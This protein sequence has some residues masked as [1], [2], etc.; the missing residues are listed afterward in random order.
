MQENRSF[1]NIFAGFPGAQ[2]ALSG[3]CRP[4]GQA[5]KWCPADHMIALHSVHLRTGTPDFGIDIDHS[6]SGFQIECNLNASNVCAMD[7]FNL[8]RY[9]E[10]GQSGFAKTYAYAYVDRKETAPYW[11]LAQQYTL[12]DKMFL[13]DT[14]SSFIAHQLILSG[15]VRINDHESLTD[16][17]FTTPWGCDAPAGLTTPFLLRDGRVIIPP[18]KISFPCFTQYRTIADLLDAKSVSYEFYVM[19]GLDAKAPNYDFSGAAWNGFDAIKKFRYSSDWKNHVSVP[20][21]NIFKD[22]KGGTLPAVSWV[23]PTLFD[24]DHP[25]SGCNGGRAG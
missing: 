11:R 15:T 13:T 21:T 1:N 17:P 4:K 10:S 3:P 18:S 16:Q 25:A 7:G 8:I 22:L 5:A 19:Q 14:A 6:H 23:I 12:A 20:N 2:T 24:S 9:G